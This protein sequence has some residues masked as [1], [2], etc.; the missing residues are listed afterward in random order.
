MSPKV[1]DACVVDTTIVH[2][3]KALSEGRA[4]EGQQELVLNWIVKIAGNYH[5]EPFVEGD[6]HATAF[7]LGR[8]FVA[9]EVMRLVQMDGAEIDAMRRKEGKR[10]G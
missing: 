6:T 4:N 3:F 8:R 2:A 1:S 7:A 9:R 5:G 10:N